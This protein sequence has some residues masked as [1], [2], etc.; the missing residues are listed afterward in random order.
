MNAKKSEK[1]KKRK[2]RV[3][4]CLQDCKGGEMEEERERINNEQI[5]LENTIKTMII[6]KTITSKT[7]ETASAE[8]IARLTRREKKIKTNRLREHV[9]FNRMS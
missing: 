4:K 1:R 6:I 9:Y 5:K 3:Q 2:K 7:H 8:N